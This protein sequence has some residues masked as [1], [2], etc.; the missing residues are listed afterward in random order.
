[1]IWIDAG[2][3]AGSPQCLR[4]C[5]GGHRLEGWSMIGLSLAMGGNALRNETRR[6]AAVRT[7]EANRCDQDCPYAALRW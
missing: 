5:F 1:M 2:G 6:R 4:F 7:I 3:R